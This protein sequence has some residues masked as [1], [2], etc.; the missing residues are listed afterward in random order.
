MAE[1]SRNQ[2]DKLLCSLFGP[3]LFSPLSFILPE[4]RSYIRPT[5]FGCRFYAICVAY[6]GSAWQISC[7]EHSH[8]IPLVRNNIVRGRLNVWWRAECAYLSWPCL[9]QPFDLY[10]FL[11]CASK[12]KELL[13][14]VANTANSCIAK[15]KG[16][17]NWLSVSTGLFGWWPGIAAQHHLDLGHQKNICLGQSFSGSHPNRHVRGRRR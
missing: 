6:L 8:N 10:F 3:R 2:L 9:L 15:K 17:R 11:L 7:T 4:S 14:N 5:H 13:F 12:N 16:T 1:I